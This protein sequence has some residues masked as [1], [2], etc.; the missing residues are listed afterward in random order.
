MVRGMD[1]AR[2]VNMCSMHHFSSPIEI[3]EEFFDNLV[4]LANKSEHNRE[5]LEKSRV[6]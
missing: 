4:D 5:L 1:L 2:N 3:Q 6:R